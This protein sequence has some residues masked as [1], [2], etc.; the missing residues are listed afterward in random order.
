MNLLLLLFHAAP[1][2]CDNNSST[3]R[4]LFSFFLSAHG[5]FI[6]VLLFNR[7]LESLVDPRSSSAPIG[8]T[9]FITHLFILAYYVTRYLVHIDDFISRKSNAYVFADIHS[10]T[11]WSSGD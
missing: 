5:A 4:R 11:R 10:F 3:Q 6:Q 7:R 1:P 9:G 2:G 8:S